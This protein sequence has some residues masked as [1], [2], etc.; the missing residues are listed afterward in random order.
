MVKTGVRV[1]LKVALLGAVVVVSAGSVARAQAPA[2][3]VVVYKTATCGCC[4][5]WVEHMRAHGFMVT[6]HDVDNIS[7]V[8]SERRVPAEAASCHTAVVDGYVVEGHV[9][10]DA[11]QRLL[12]ER[13]SVLGIAVPGMPVG[14]PGM[15]MP[16]GRRDPYSIVTFDEDGEIRHFESR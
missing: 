4:R 9:P 5:N 11:V 16:S 10:A 15:E 13:P 2:P 14:S 12:Q 8:K 3:E 7:Q 1:A 6:S